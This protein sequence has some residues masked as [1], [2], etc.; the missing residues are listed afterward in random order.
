MILMQYILIGIAA[1]GI[2]NLGIQLSQKKI[3]ISNSIKWFLLWGA[4]IVVA[5]DPDVATRVANFFGI[6]RGVDFV[7]Y[8]AFIFIF[9]LIFKILLKINYLD[10][11]ITKIINHLAVKDSK[12]NNQENNELS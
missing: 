1:I 8:A 11:N 9:F 7:M 6:G 5:V 3:N 2:I 12:K 10:K 4:I